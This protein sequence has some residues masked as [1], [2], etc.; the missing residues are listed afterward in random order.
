MRTLYFDCSCGASGDMIVGALLDAGANFDTL[1]TALLSLGVE[2]FDLYA[3]KVNK[4]GV[5]ATQFTVHVQDHDHDDEH[6]HDHKHD[7][8]HDHHGHHDKHEHKHSHKHDHAHK[9]VHQPHRGLSDILHIIEHGN[10]PASV[11][12][13]SAATFTRIA[14]CEAAIHGSTVEAIHF[15]EVGGVDSI[16]DIVGAHLGM[17]L[18]GV[19]QVI[20][21]PLNVGSGTVKIAH[22]VLPVPAPA[23]VMLLKGAPSYGSEVLA[24][25]VTPTGA[26]VITGLATAYGPQPAMTVDRIG[27]GSGMKDLPDRPNVLRVSIGELTVS[28]ALGDDV[29]VMETTI[30][31]MNPELLPSLIATLLAKGARDATLTPILGKKG[32][33]A[34]LLTVLCDEA[35]KDTLAEVVF[36]GSTTFGIRY[37]VERRFC[38]DRT[39][40]QVATPWGNVRVKIGQYNG[41]VT[42]MAP[43][44]EDCRQAAEAHAVSVRAVYDAA[45]A[46]AV[47]GELLND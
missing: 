11:K 21:S 30:D 41:A 31:D 28:P 40:K 2:G 36:R 35:K 7:H 3:E 34:Y 16:V 14:E 39:W 20:A 22:G 23:T 17:H 12:A 6:E 18:L 26:A 13:A 47:K 44:Y 4:R 37:R 10:L 38:L 32:R 8:G 43:E 24:E 5:M 45:H 9:E 42:S 29:L 27:Y 19:E 46:A 25:L 1:R 33:P 15:H